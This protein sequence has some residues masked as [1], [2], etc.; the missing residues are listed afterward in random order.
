MIIRL[1]EFLNG[2]IRKMCVCSSSDGKGYSNKLYVFEPN[3]E[4]TVEDEVSKEFFRGN[5]GAPN[6][7]MVKTDQIVAELKHYGVPYTVTKC[8]T[9]PSAKARVV[10]NPFKIVEDD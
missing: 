4:Y 5:V 2:A 7:T 9:C 10:F 8:G 6:E 3:T 1:H